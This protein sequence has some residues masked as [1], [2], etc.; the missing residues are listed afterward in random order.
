MEKA[1]GFCANNAGFTSHFW[2]VYVIDKRHLFWYNN[3]VNKI[4]RK[5]NYFMKNVWK[6]IV[7]VLALFGALVGALVIVDKIK[8]KN[9]IKGEYLEC[10]EAEDIPEV[11]D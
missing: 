8:N 4:F 1:F 11:D 7:A 9:R 6:V 3:F 10:D 2:A 5:A